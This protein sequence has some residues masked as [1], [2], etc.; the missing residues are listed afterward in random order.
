MS[1]VSLDHPH[2]SLEKEGGMRACLEFLPVRGVG[3]TLP[4][5]PIHVGPREARL[6]LASCLTQTQVGIEFLELPLACCLWS[7]FIPK[8][9]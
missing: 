5:P 8:T 2:S 3:S 9:I 7:K 4:F 6:R 1:F